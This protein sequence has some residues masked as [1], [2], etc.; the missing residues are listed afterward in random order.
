M[1]TVRRPIALMRGAKR[2]ARARARAWPGTAV[3][4]A[5][6][7]VQLLAAL[8][9]AVAAPTQAS[10]SNQEAVAELMRSARLWQALEHADAEREVLRKLLAVQPDQPRALFLLGE[11]ELRAGHIEQ[12]R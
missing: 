11:L 5:L 10:S 12:A 9:R 2:R 3:L 4:V 7:T 1:A 6:L 8:P